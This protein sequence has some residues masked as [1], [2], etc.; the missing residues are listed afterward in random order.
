MS[1]HIPQH[2]VI[3]STTSW[4]TGG[5]INPALPETLPKCRPLYVH[6]TATN[7]VTKS[8]SY[9]VYIT[10]VVKTNRCKNHK[11]CAVGFV[12][13]RIVETCQE[14]RIYRTVG[15]HTELLDQGLAVCYG[16]PAVLNQS[17]VC[18]DLQR[19]TAWWCRQWYFHSWFQW[20][21]SP[22]I[23]N[24]G[25]SHLRG[26]YSRVYGWVSGPSSLATDVL[27][28]IN[29]STTVAS[30]RGWVQLEQS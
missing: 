17:L 2:S 11:V 13:I 12:Y 9:N 1:T 20:V 16:N 10:I 15:I 6:C 14:R 22:R 5:W 8:V 26:V 28:I 3:C 29:V 18:T 7:T 25:Y 30:Q 4:L 19:Q 24:T 27:Y 21:P 23:D